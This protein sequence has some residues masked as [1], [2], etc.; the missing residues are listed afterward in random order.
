MAEASEY[1][2]TYAW[3]PQ[4][5]GR[6]DLLAEVAREIGASPVER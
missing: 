6:A 2:R 1:A 4:R 5:A 3:Y